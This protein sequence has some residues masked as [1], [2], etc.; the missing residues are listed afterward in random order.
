VEGYGSSMPN[1]IEE[2]WNELEGKMA[3]SQARIAGF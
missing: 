2:A 1:E 3:L